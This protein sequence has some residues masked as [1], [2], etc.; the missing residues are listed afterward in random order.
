M[1]M[2]R[3]LWVQI[4][5]DEGLEALLEKLDELQNTGVTEDVELIRLSKTWYDNRVGM[6]RF[7]SLS[8]DVWKE[9]S[10]RFYSKEKRNHGCDCCQGDEAL[11][12]KDNENN[13]F[14]DSKGEILTTVKGMTM[15]YKV[16]CCPS[17]GKEF[18]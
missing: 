9:A 18:V 13:A 11:Y 7:L 16:K 10:F 14:V 5:T 15:R 2:H 4:L 6:E 8:I 1:I 17:C 12:W 3:P